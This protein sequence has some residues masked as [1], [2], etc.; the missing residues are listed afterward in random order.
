MKKYI[1][2]FLLLLI[3]GTLCAQ[4]SVRLSFSGRDAQNHY[5]QLN[6]VI[7]TDVTVGWQDTL[8]W[9]DT[10]LIIGIPMGIDEMHTTTTGK[11]A[12]HLSP[13]VPNPFSGST[14]VYLTTEQEGRV[15]LDITDLNGRI[16]D[17]YHSPFLQPGT[18]QFHITLANAGLYL[19]TARQNGHSSSVKMV[20]NGGGNTNKIEEKGVV[21]SSVQTAPRQFRGYTSHLFHRGDQMTFVGYATIGGNVY[22]SHTIAQAQQGSESFQLQFDATLPAAVDGQPCPSTPTLTDIDGNIYNTV[23][24][25][26]QCWMKE[27]LRTT[28]FANGNPIQHGTEHSDSVCYYYYPN[29]DTNTVGNDGLLYNWKTVMNNESGN[30]N[31]PSGRQGVC[32]DGWH[33]PSL[34][35]WNV[36]TNYVGSRSQWLCDG[37]SG[38]IA[39]A[40]ASDSGWVSGVMDCA[41]GVNQ[42][43][44]NATHFTGRPTG[45]FVSSGIAN[46][47]KF[48]MYWTCTSSGTNVAEA[49]YLAYTLG[50]VG[51]P[52]NGYS[53]TYGLGVRCV[54]DEGN[55]GGSSDPDDLNSCPVTSPNANET[56]SGGRITALRD[57]DNNSYRVVKIGNQCWMKDNLR[58]KHYADGTSISQGS[59]SMFALTTS[60]SY[61]FYPDGNTSYANTYG[62]LYNWKA[63]IR[64]ISN[65][66]TSNPSG[67][68]GVCPNGWHLPSEAEYT[69]MTN[70]VQA[71]SEYVCNPNNPDY[72]ATAFA[73]N[74]GWNSSSIQCAPGN[75]LSA[76]NATG[77]N[78]MPAGQWAQEH[79]GF[80]QYASFWG[81]SGSS[82]TAYSWNLMMNHPYPVVSY[83]MSEWAY[84]VRCV[85]N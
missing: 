4:D 24:L 50:T 85:R 9:P 53:T 82:S 11:A 48:A 80:N 41:V 43:A 42:S 28:R 35:E 32:P 39:K 45:G 61:Y 38:N 57:Y 23:Q 83:D 68:Q 77:F 26:G 17:T 6:Q 70:Y 13:N 20:N 22:E 47:G 2:T 79:S 14:D 25:G 49:L 31:V 40:L 67:V 33:V 7:V 60:V 59:N 81:A 21:L 19:L 29:D 5:V 34:A 30:N 66:S 65:A 37:E 16:V 69:Q 55:G 75:N 58:T 56:G 62:L 1:F 54:R 64:T 10:V 72:V 84:S 78:A 63:A 76:N 12:I 8:V 15:T 18:H 52:S 46:H 74:E 3:S 71:Q 44:N 73:S 36:L 51:N 27:N